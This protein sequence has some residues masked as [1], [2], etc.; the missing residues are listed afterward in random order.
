VKFRPL[1]RRVVVRVS[2]LKT[3]PLTVLS[4][5]IPPRRDPAKAKSFAGGRDESGRVIAIDL[6]VGDQVLF[7]K[8]L[9]GRVAFQDLIV[10]PKVPA[11]K[12]GS[13]E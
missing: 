11:E 5:L 4:S 10:F 13:H 8:W 9:K 12:R 6:K 1:H 2:R 3:R 7:G